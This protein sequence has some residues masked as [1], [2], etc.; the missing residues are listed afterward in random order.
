MDL[1]AALTQAGLTRLRLLRLGSSI[2]LQASRDFEPSADFTGYGHSLCLD[3]VPCAEPAVLGDEA[4][5]RILEPAAAALL[6]L[7]GWMR[8]GRHEMVLLFV[9][10]GLGIRFCHH[11]HSSALGLRNGFH[12]LRAGGIR[13]HASDAAEREVL[14]DG[15]NLARAMSFKCAAAQMPFGGSKTTLQ[16]EPVDPNDDARLGF[17]GWCIDQGNL[18]TGP[19]VGLSPE[20]IDAL[21][22]RV[23]PHILCG[24]TGPLGHTGGPTAEGVFAAM[25]AAAVHRFG[26]ESFAGRRVA[27]QGL[28]SVGLALGVR[29]A[30]Q[31]A[32]ITAADPDPE[33]IALARSRIPNLEVVAPQR[34]LEVECD[35]LSP[36]AL[37]GVLTRKSISSLRCAMVYGGANNQLDAFTTEE[38]VALA[39]LLAARGILFQPDWSYTMGGILNGF[40]E[41]QRRADASAAK[42]QA[43][44]WRLCGA[45]TRELLS[46][47]EAADKTPTALAIEGFFPRIHPG[48]RLPLAR[49]GIR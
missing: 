26:S 12:A 6:E 20:I 16:S 42:V 5:R 41:Y 22:K 25:Q 2:Q 21:A 11:I 38:E 46:A 13:R 18:M 27:I 4:A 19:D 7:E 45:G 14:R 3:Q 23:T 35:V 32:S 1:S 47:A 33:R 49:A 48:D 31:G 40:E 36:C 17:I 10:A 44:I 28:G 8:A 9:H 30:Q 34:I 29:L 39:E 37:G 15:L 43:D 24:P